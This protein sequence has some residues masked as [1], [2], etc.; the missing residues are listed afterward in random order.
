MNIPILFIVILL[1]I[2]FDLT[3]D[4]RA[5][6]TGQLNLDQINVERGQNK[7]NSLDILKWICLDYPLTD[8]R[9]QRNETTKMKES[10]NDETVKPIREFWY[11]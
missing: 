11:M 10:Q 6:R 7:E 8:K 2:N 9:T 1:N 5:W 3:F 4:L